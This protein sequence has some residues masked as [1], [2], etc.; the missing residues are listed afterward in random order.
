MTRTLIALGT[1]ALLT[2]PAQAQM[3]NLPVI[4]SG[5]STG[6]GIAADVGFPNQDAG[7]GTAL[8]ATGQLGLGPFGVTGSVAT[9]NPQGDGGS[10]TSVGGTANLKIFGGPLIPLSVTL[11]AGAARWKVD[12]LIGDIT[13]L[14]VPVGVGVA[15]VIPNPA[16]AIKP[17]LA[18]RL[19]FT[20]ISATGL[21]SNNDVNFGFSAGVDFT[22]LSGLGFRAAY[23]YV[24]ADGATPS[25]FS[26]GAKY[27]LKVPGL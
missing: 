15:L 4:N 18:P 3:L 11:Q 26:L 22:L 12:G 13:T 8:G 5:I 1:A 16:L 23:D 17:W 21:D 20:R 7:K 19:D 6:I 9:Y 14:H 10:I 2:I 25:V 27:V 24:K